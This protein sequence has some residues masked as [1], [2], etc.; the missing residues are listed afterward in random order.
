[1]L[2]TIADLTRYLYLPSKEITLTIAGATTSG[3]NISLADGQRYLQDAEARV[4]RAVGDIPW[5]YTRIATAYAADAVSLTVDKI[6]LDDWLASGNIYFSG[7]NVTYTG[8]TTTG[9]TGLSSDYT[10]PAS[11]I[12][13]FVIDGAIVDGRT[14]LGYLKNYEAELYRRL[15]IICKEAAYNIW[16]MRFPADAM[17]KVIDDWKQEVNRY[18][19]AATSGNAWL[20]L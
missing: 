1:M 4:V 19:A 17:P 9:F 3:E 8:R 12:G 15:E 6:D 5:N 18:I 10:I 16:I 20:H 11:P 13:T 14:G 2:A 7:S